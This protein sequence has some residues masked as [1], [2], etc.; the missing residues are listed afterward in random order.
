M[1]SSEQRFAANR[2]NAQKS[3]GPCSLE[4]KRISSGNATRHG[5]LSTRLFLD[6]EDPD[7]FADL[8]CDL[9]RSL[10]PVGAME[11]ALVER[12]AVTLW[13]QRR[14]VTAETA[15]LDLGRQARQIAGGVSD[16]LGLKYGSALKEE[17]LQ[18]FDPDRIAWCTATIS[19]IEALDQIDLD[20]LPQLAPNVFNQLEADADGEGLSAYLAGHENGLT[21]YVDALM[22]W[23]R[24]ELSEAERRPHV[25]VLPV[26]ERAKHLLL[27]DD[28]LQVIARY[29][30]T[31]DNQLYK[32]LT[33]LREA[34]E[35]RLK[36]LV[37][38]VDASQE[39]RADAA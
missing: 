31:L 24:S 11:L 36:T 5:L 33:A 6:D 26:Q 35:W 25:Q 19:E 16:E 12:I 10:T 18:P 20:S 2:I 37:G 39:V 38:R 17:D 29:Q 15:A 3:T 23:C 21:G 34:Q 28:T 7:E 30:T 1:S 27:P 13:R 4:G 8:L 9:Q 32:A 22:D 14:L